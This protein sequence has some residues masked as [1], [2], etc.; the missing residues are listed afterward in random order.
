MLGKEMQSIK[1]VLKR[2]EKNRKQLEKQVEAIDKIFYN[3]DKKT[4]DM[5]LTIRQ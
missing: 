4:V 1:R 3:F 2:L 5:I